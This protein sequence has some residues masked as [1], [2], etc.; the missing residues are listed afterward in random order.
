MVL[1]GLCETG[2]QLKAS[3]TDGLQFSQIC[4][5]D[6]CRNQIDDP[7]SIEALRVSSPTLGE[8]PSEHC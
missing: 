4:S 6:S 2:F 3:D 1:G 7:P 5:T 8:G